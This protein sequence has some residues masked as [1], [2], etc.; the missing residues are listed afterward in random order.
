[1]AR[2]S[3]PPTPAEPTGHP[4]PRPSAPG[5]RRA[6]T[7]DRAARWFLYSAVGWLLAPGLVGLLL[8]TFLYEPTVQDHLPEALKPYVIFG[9]LRPVHVDLML[10]GWLSL[11]YAGTML[12][13]TP[14]LVGAP[15]YSERLARA[16]LVLWHLVLVA[17]VLGLAAGGNQGR[18]YAE[19]PWPVKLGVIAV[20]RG[21]SP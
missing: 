7:P 3:P 19:F 6:V 14:R 15:L 12:Y 2:T 9:R 5:G 4:V 11:T 10:F 17:A 20:V 8:A 16:T 18:K 21:E 1:M 13:V